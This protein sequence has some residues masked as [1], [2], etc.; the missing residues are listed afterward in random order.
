MSLRTFTENIVNLAVESCLVTHIADILT[1]SMVYRMSDEK[2]DELAA[3]SYDVERK[4]EALKR[5]IE[6]LEE[7]RRVCRRNKPRESNGM[8]AARSRRGTVCSCCGKTTDSG[9]QYFQT[10]L[11]APLP[12][13]NPVSPS[14]S[15]P[16]PP[17]FADSPAANVKC[18]ATGS[19]SPAPA[20]SPKPVPT[21][22]AAHPTSIFSTQ[23]KIPPVLFG[24]SQAASNGNAAASS[25]T[26]SP[27]P[28]VASLFP[29]HVPTVK[30]PTANS[31]FG[32]G[33][34]TG[35]TSATSAFGPS[36]GSGT[37]SVFAVSPSSALGQARNGSPAA[38]GTSTGSS[39]AFGVASNGSPSKT[40]APASG[41]AASSGTRTSS[42]VKKS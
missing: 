11:A 42:P 29:P 5:D 27:A 12:N 36:S 8:L 6:I 20:P 35:G 1:P 18:S 10:F 25:T 16:S 21:A 38:S 37:P 39:A 13:R 40:A 34:S 22:I 19:V 41:P 28:W 23:S 32:T 3:E 30:L 17:A 14:P 9:S 26:M 15:K 33:T 2:L 24:P 4:R 31:L 7:C